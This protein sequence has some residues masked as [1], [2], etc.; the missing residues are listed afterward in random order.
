MTLYFT[1][2]RCPWLNLRLSSPGLESAAAQS[3]SLTL[4]SLRLLGL[5][6]PDAGD[7][8]VHAPHHPAAVHYEAQ[9]LH[10]RHFAPPGPVG[11]PQ[12]H[13]L[14]PSSHCRSFIADSPIVAKIQYW[15]KITFVFI[16]ILFI[17]SVNRVYRVQVEL[18]AVSEQAAKGS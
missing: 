16:L 4:A 14:L 7:D 18:H 5:C 8:S 9:D 1:L 6:A 12:K 15:M 3:L 2:V 10:V 17:D 11:C 13:D